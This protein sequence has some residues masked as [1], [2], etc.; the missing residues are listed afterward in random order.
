MQQI[1]KAPVMASAKQSVQTRYKLLGEIGNEIEKRTE[2]SLHNVLLLKELTGERS[3]TPPERPW[4]VEVK[5]GNQPSVRLL[6]G[7]KIIEIFDL[8]TTAGKLLILGAAGSGKT[9]TLLELA[10]DLVTRALNDPLQP[11][12]VLFNLCSWQEDRQTIATW[13]VAELQSKYGVIV[14]IG[15]KWLSEGQLLPLLDG[16]DELRADWQKPCIQDINQ[17]LLNYQPKHLVVCSSLAEYASGKTLLQMNAAIYLL[18]LSEAQIYDYLSRQGLQQLWQSIQKDSNLL[19]WATSPLFLNVIALAAEEISLQEWLQRPTPETR[20]RYLLDA[21]IRRMLKWEYGDRP[22]FTQ[23]APSPEQTR[24]WLSALAKR[25]QRE[26]TDEFSISDIQ[27]TWLPSRDR[28]WIYRPIVGLILGLIAGLSCFGSFGLTAGLISGLL[29]GLIGG[30]SFKIQPAE[31]LNWSWEKAKSGVRIGMSVGLLA[32]LVGGLFLG[33]IG[34]LVGGLFGLMRA[35]IG[36]LI[37]GLIVGISQGL[38]EPEIKTNI[39]PNQ[40]IWHS[41][42][43]AG[44]FT[45]ISG[46]SFGLSFGLFGGP[47]RGL[48]GLGL[49]VLTGLACGGIPCIQHLALRLILFLQGSIPWNYARFLDYASD[50]LFLQK[51][52]GRYR[53]VHDL[54]RSHFAAPPPGEIVLRQ[55]PNSQLVNTI[56]GHLEQV[57]AIAVSPQGNFIVSGSDDKTIKIWQAIVGE[58]GRPGVRPIRT[59]SGHTDYVRAVAISPDGQVLAS[60]SNDKTIRLWMLGSGQSGL[61]QGTPLIAL[62]GHS[63]WVR[64]VAFSPNGQLLASCGDD[65]TINIW[66][67]RT[68]QLLNVLSGHT[69][70]IRCLAFSPDGQTLATGSDDKTIDIWNLGIDGRTSGEPILTLEGHSGYVRCLTFSPDGQFL[71]SGSDDQTLTIW[72]FGIDEEG[73]PVVSPLNILVGHTG[74]IWSVAISPDGKML[75][76]SSRDKT[77]KIWDLLAGDLLRTLSVGPGWVFSVAFSPDGKTLVSGGQDRRIGIWPL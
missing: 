71:V 50:R 77:I 17:F 16:L 33:L 57:H 26:S 35:G 67:L 20:T 6:P 73:R 15:R 21:Y 11:I 43:T 19:N 2:Q 36:G 12:P 40:D 31:P 54:L 51:I 30:L 10:R 38:N 7:K 5:I 49:G 1:I 44:V 64:S 22:S 47:L 8:Q 75:A 69:D 76:S 32:G 27:P 63:N 29:F 62:N 66:Y 34:E 68:G 39:S 18:P 25:L 13:L 46:V 70:Y 23:E 58:D 59:L 24:H 74:L 55:L 53:F 4:D 61:A 56:A 48:G 14:E 52:G 3:P 42:S 9:T 28:Q 72:Q 41:A 65:T 45:L 60:G 37:G